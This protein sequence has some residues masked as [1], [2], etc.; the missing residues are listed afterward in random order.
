[1][2][3]SFDHGVKLTVAQAAVRFLAAQASERDGLSEPL[4]AGVYGIFGHGNVTGLGQALAQEAS[5]RYYQGRNEQSMVHTAI[6]YARARRRRSTLACASSIGP[7]STNMVTGAATATINRLPVL[8]LPAD[9]YA[10]RLQGNVLQQLEHP[11]EADVSVNDCLRPVS[12]FFDRILRPEQLLTALPEAMR[13]LTDPAATGA[14]TISMPQDVQTESYRFPTRFFEPREWPI[15]RPQPDTALVDRVVDILS[16]AHRPALIAGGGVHFSEAW[17]ELAAFADAF[18]IPVAETFAGKGA[19]RE[20]YDLLLGGV[21]VEGTPAANAVMRQADLVLCIGTRLS[22]FITASRSLFQNPNVRFVGV[23]VNAHDASKLAAL[24][25]VADARETLRALLDVGRAKGLR[26]DPTYRGEVRELRDAW[27]GRL[28][29]AV[30]PGGSSMSQGQVIRVLQESSK[31][32]DLVVAAAGAPVGDLLKQWDA[33]DGRPAHLEFGYSCMGHEIP[34]AIGARLATEDAGEV[35]ALVGDGTFL[36]NPVD[37][38]SAIQEGLKITVV[39]TDNHGFQAIRRLQLFRVGI[40][41]GNEF[42]AR[43]DETGQLDG[44]YLSLDHAGLAEALGAQAWRVSDEDGL[45]SALSAARS[46]S[47]PCVIVAEIEK[48]SFLP[49]SEVWWDAP[50]PEVATDPETQKRRFEYEAGRAGQR[51]LG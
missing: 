48:Q 40:S 32:G 18:G 29:E 13:I 23:N 50:A 45:R 39:V 31:T 26:P 51:Y 20:A 24:T 43:N 47:G 49:G 1:M 21:G 34:A 25:I 3:K 42:R 16:S 27:T 2:S 17:S 44:P 33:T 15:R 5:L 46:A 37:I 28:A 10:T 7:G 6:G 30:A 4:I 14:V 36:L 19:M 9:Y 35:I 38:A 8:L 11:V 12:R 41:F 22:D